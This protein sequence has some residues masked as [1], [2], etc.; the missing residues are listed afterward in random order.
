MDLNEDVKFIENVQLFSDFFAAVTHFLRDIT[1][2][3]SGTVS[4]LLCGYADTSSTYNRTTVTF[5]IKK[6]K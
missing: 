5:F 6:G 2:I 4:D 3:K 1:D